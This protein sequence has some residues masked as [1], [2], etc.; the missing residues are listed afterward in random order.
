MKI[1]MKIA[2]KIVRRGPQLKPVNHFTNSA[3]NKP[4]RCYDLENNP[5]IYAGKIN[6]QKNQLSN[7]KLLP[8]TI[9]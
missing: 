6:F 2:V 9:T 3:T 4:R 5:N 7:I 1:F 8:K